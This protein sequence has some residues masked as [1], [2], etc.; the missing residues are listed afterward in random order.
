MPSGP[1]TNRIARSPGITIYLDK[2]V[3]M[4]VSVDWLSWNDDDDLLSLSFYFNK[5]DQ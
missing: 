2:L 1:E 4:H 5:I 3:V